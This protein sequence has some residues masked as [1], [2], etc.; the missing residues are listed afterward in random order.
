MASPA[1][2]GKAKKKWGTALAMPR[3]FGQV[4][5]P[6]WS[7]RGPQHEPHAAAFEPHSRGPVPKG[8]KGLLRFSDIAQ[9]IGAC[10]P[11]YALNQPLQ[12]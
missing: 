10:S 4:C 12:E 5:C 7:V 9:R 6:L 8:H 2:G 1:W 11:F 3:P